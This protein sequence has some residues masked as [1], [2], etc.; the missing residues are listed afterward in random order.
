M[1]LATDF[2]W[3]ASSQIYCKVTYHHNLGSLRGDKN[4]R[5]PVVASKR[6]LKLGGLVEASCQGIVR[7]KKGRNPTGSQVL[8]FCIEICGEG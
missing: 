8:G 5:S 3:Q 4:S 6:E 7:I 2:L 1:Y